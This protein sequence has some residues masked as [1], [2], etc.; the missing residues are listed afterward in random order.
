MLDIV[1]IKVLKDK[2]QDDFL[3]IQRNEKVKSVKGHL[4]VIKYRDKDTRQIVLVIPSLDLSSYGAT[5]KKAFEMMKF[6]IENFLDFLMELSQKNMEKELSKLGW[7]HSQLRKK[8]YSKAFVDS[9]GE[10]KN[11]NAVG[12][13]VE[14]VSIAI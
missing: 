11:F 7:K 9:S 5:E 2:E 13:K 14:V 10:L 1:K 3:R 4:K 8:E 12:D 6:T